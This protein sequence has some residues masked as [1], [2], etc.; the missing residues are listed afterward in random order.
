MIVIV[1]FGENGKVPAVEEVELLGHWIRRGN[2]NSSSMMAGGC[3]ERSCQSGPVTE[4]FRRVWVAS[5]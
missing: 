3:A 4:E 1:E 2:S 5:K